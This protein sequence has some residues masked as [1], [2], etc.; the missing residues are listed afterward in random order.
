MV[1]CACSTRRGIAL[2]DRIDLKSIDFVDGSILM[3]PSG[4]RRVCGAWHGIGVMIR[5]W[6][7]KVEESKIGAA[8]VSSYESLRSID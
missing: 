2:L 3:G 4:E 7:A 8:V 6:E 5:L 1:P